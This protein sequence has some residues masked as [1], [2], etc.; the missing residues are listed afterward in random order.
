MRTRG[1]ALPFAAAMA[2]ALLALVPALALATT[3]QQ[4][5]DRAVT[6]W[7]LTCQPSASDITCSGGRIH[8]GWVAVITPA[9]GQ[10]TKLHTSAPQP[11]NGGTLDTTARSWMS[12]LHA[13]ACG[14]TKG[15]AAFVNQVGDLSSAGSIKQ[16]QVGDCL[17]DGSLS[18]PGSLPSVYT[19]LSTFHP[20]P[21]PSPTL[22]P[23]AP[24]TPKP[25]VT[26]TATAA[27]TAS[28]TPDGTATATTSG[29]AEP[30][31]SP[32]A[33]A[34]PSPSSS[35]AVSPI[36]VTP[37]PTSSPAPPPGGCT[38]GCSESA[39]VDSIPDLGDIQTDAASI[40]GSALFALVLLLIGF[41]AE[42]FNN[43]V[44]NNYDVFSAWFKKGPLG[45]WSAW[46]QRHVRLGVGG[47]LLLT[48]LVSA[49]VDPQFGPNERGLIEFLG[50]LV[51]VIVV[52]ASFKLPP[53]LAHRRK[54][55]ELG[56]LRPLPW[57]LVISA[58]F[59]LVSRLGNLQ[60]GYLYGIILG[61]IFTREVSD[62]E[63]GRETVYGSIWTL[64]AALISWVLLTAVRNQGLPATDLFNLFAQTAL[65]CVLVSGLEATAFGLMPLRF[66]PGYLIYRWNRP[67]WAVLFGLS[68]FAFIHILIGPTSGYVSALNPAAFIVA[69]GVFAIF[70]AFSI[71]TWGYFRFR[72]AP[73]AQSLER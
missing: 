2:A 38:K 54:T 59:V 65:G 72:P 33:S 18:P 58:L 21:T 69:G 3:A 15:V 63:E 68:V 51:G 52:L 11:A 27:P 42:L 56:R 25:T 7:S 70:G 37:A 39:F 66:M 50:V 47:F 30:T 44:E 61:A 34:A 57:A 22:K 53:M 23:T 17:M 35:G 67:L 49:F 28:P 10:F 14:D 45:G 31:T 40:G 60:P 48:A 64:F 29:S 16:A 5:A 20:L 41:A 73:E 32:S 71:A 13:L 8:P 24:P 4:I 43:T 1:R 62:D 46:I 6:A 12:D 19:V 26:P 55:G 36:F 9:S